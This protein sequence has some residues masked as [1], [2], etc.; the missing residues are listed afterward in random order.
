MSPR[1]R[2]RDPARAAATAARVKLTPVRKRE[3]DAALFAKA[4]IAAQLLKTTTPP[5]DDSRK[6]RPHEETDHHLA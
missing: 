2:P 4:V 6:E 1:G 5:I 3:I